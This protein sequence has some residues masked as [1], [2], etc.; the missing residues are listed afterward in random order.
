MNTRDRADFS[1]HDQW[2]SYVRRA[3]PSD[4]QHYVLALG[5]TELF[6]SSYEL[7]GWLFPE[8][9]SRELEH[10]AG[11][12]DP[13]RTAALESLNRR[14]LSSL[15]DILCAEAQTAVARMEPRRPASGR[16]QTEELLKEL[17]ATNPYFALC[18]DYRQA[19][20]G[21]VSAEERDRYLRRRLGPDAEDDFAFAR[22]MMEL[23]GLLR[24]F[25]DRNLRLPTY[26]RER[27]WFLHYLCEPERGLQ[28]RALLNTLTAEIE[29]CTSA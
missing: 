16:E 3:V 13:D 1:D 19:S 11:L 6:R 20:G 9:S 4:R 29:A 18:T 24:F 10:I 15:T 28:T 25:R 26:F 2:T 17:N 22:S 8:T 27:V 21:D 12:R 7:R 5:L 14:I 23:D